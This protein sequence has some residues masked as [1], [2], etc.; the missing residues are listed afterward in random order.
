MDEARIK[1]FVTHTPN[2]VS[3]K[4]ELPLFE[5]VLAGADFQKGGTDLV[6][7]NTGDHI[8]VKNKSYCELTTQYWAWKNTDY[9]YYGF[10]HYRR[11]FSFSDQKLEESQWGTIE[12]PYINTRAILELQ[13]DEDTI[14]KKVTQYDFLIAKGIRTRQLGADNVRE[15]YKNAAELHVEDFDIMMDVI[16]QK[17]PDFY[18]AADKYAKGD[19]SYPCNMFIMKK[20]LFEKYSEFLFGVLAECEKRIDTSLYCVQSFRTIGHLAERLLGIYYVYLQ[21]QGDYRL[22]T[23]QIALF[24]NTDTVE[25]VRPSCKEAVPVVL[26]ANDY[27]APILCTCLES[28]KEH[29]D[30][31]NQYDIV[32][33]HTDITA[34][35]Q[36][37]ISG[38]LKGLKNIR[39]TFIN[40]GSIVADYTLDA[41]EHITT[42][43]FYRFLILD[44]M[45][46]YE[47]VIYLDC[48]LVVNA[49]LALLHQVEMGDRLIAATL[50]A[51]FIGQLN[52]PGA[53]TL[54]YSKETLKL[55]DPYA[56]FQAGVLIFNV[57]QMRRVTTVKELLE[58]SDQDL[59]RYS[60]QDILNVLCQG[61]VAYLDL[62]W[63]HIFD[64][65]GE[66]IKNVIVWDP[67]PLYEAYMEAKKD[68][69]IIHYAGFCKPWDEPSEEF[70]EVFWEYARRTPYYEVLVQRLAKH[71]ADNAVHDNHKKHYISLKSRIIYFFLPDGSARRDKAR[72]MWYK[73][74]GR[75]EK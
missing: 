73:V 22:G 18:P 50:D 62:K 25:P 33:F 4:I 60:D 71:M 38:I 40:I 27:Y 10:C 8:S 3:Q 2:K 28:I 9:D 69:Y 63:N 35:N 72:E 70:G 48:D 43:T 26:A 13:I 46:H 57:P 6:K 37:R 14:Q 39:L 67:V 41:R 54:A 17:Y 1:I 15:H 34:C 23:L 29:T 68:P 58:I 45:E 59:Y 74:F 16:R 30:P 56:Y 53:T 64:C 20:E 36:R 32:I 47:K 51:D 44:L 65:Y 12:Y 75:P 7:D 24:K 42:E 49:D 55:K 5:H 19:V 21:E 61:R 11:Y 31:E 66:R 52:I